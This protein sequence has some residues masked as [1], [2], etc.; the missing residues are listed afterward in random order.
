MDIFGVIPIIIFHFLLLNKLICYECTYRFNQYK[1]HGG[2]ILQQIEALKN[3]DVV[4]FQKD[5]IQ[6]F[7]NEQR[8]LPWR[9]I[10]TRIKFG[11]QRLC[12]SKHVLIR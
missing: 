5:L 7:E 2:T 1:H 9:K 11:F 8:S 10:E 12:S 6:W 4:S 3:F